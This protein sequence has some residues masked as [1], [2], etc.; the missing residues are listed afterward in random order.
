MGIKH[1]NDLEGF[2]ELF[3]RCWK[4][5][6]SL[7]FITQYYFSVPKEVTFNSTHYLIMKIH[8]KRELKN[9]AT[10]H[11]ADIDYNDF[12]NIYRKCTSE[13]Y[14]FLA[15]DTTLPANNPLRFRKSLL[16]LLYKND[17]N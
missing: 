11:S 8:N 5:N 14:S 6:I 4:L 9:L 7:V 13:P 16:N 15:I 3:T 10:N 2:I 12:I 17:I 1:L